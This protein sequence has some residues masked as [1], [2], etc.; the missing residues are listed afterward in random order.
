MHSLFSFLASS[1]GRVVRGVAGALLV[2]LGLWAIG[3]V[4]GAVIAVIGL[5]PL[6]AG[7]FDFCIF[8]PLAGL[9][10]NGAPLRTT[11]QKRLS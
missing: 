6:A 8:A 4:A 2:V 3:G 9:P 5:L 7:V 10:F 1:T 11:L